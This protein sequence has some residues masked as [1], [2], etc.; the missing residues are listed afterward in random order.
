MDYGTGSINILN[1]LSNLRSATAAIP[2]IPYGTRVIGKYARKLELLSLSPHKVSCF[3][4]FSLSRGVFCIFHSSRGGGF[5]SLST[6]FVYSSF[7][8]ND[9]GSASI[10]TRR[11]DRRSYSSAR[12]GSPSSNDTVCISPSLS[13]GRMLNWEAKAIYGQ[14][15]ST[16][17]FPG[18]SMLGA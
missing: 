1:G 17:H 9:T 6:W 5:G 12:R 3:F 8:R 2:R 15:T 11:R 7:L 18:Q 4:L 14:L 16:V 10:P 13:C